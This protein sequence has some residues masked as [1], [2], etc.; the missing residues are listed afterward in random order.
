MRGGG[1]CAVYR[2]FD[3][4]GQLLY[5]GQSPSPLNRAHEH[6]RL[7]PWSY[8]MVRVEIQWFD[9][10]AAAKAEEKR[11]IKE[12]SPRWN[13]HHQDD[14][15]QHRSRGIFHPDFRRDDPSTWEKSNG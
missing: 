12:E 2:C 11:A 9:N 1:P 13:V 6:S 3:A 4:A 8:E 7:K 5:V 10:R 14:P 15:S